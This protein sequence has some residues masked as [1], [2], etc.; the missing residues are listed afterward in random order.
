MRRALPRGAREE[1][2]RPLHQG[3]S[4]RNGIAVS[5][6]RAAAKGYSKQ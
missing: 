1:A 6:A 5:P 3:M 2:A 4:Q